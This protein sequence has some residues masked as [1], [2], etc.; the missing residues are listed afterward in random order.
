[1]KNLIGRKVKGFKFERGVILYP[2]LTDKHIGEIGKI[3]SIGDDY[4]LVQF[5][6]GYWRYPLDQ[7]EAHLIPEVT[8]EEAIELLESQ[9]YKVTKEIPIGAM[10]LFSDVKDEF[11]NNIGWVDTFN[12]MDGDQF[13][14]GVGVDWKLCKQI[15]IT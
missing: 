13:N 14:S 5:K 15:T 11:E 1:M 4:V 8:T 10:C 2:P 6:D 12:G 3:K 9:G 7:I